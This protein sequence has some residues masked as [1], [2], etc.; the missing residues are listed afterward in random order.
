VRLPPSSLGALDAFAA[1][2]VAEPHVTPDPSL[3]NLIDGGL[4]LKLVT[5]V[6]REFWR[7]QLGDS[8]MTRA[9]V[10]LAEKLGVPAVILPW[11]ALIIAGFDGDEFIERWTEVSAADV[12]LEPYVC[13]L[14][15][16]GGDVIES[17]YRCL[18]EA[19]SKARRAASAEPRPV[20]E[21][22]H[23]RR[24]GWWSR[25]VVNQGGEGWLAMPIDVSPSRCRWRLDGDDPSGLVVDVLNSEEVAEVGE[26]AAVRL[27]GWA[28]RPLRPGSPTGLLATRIADAA[29][30]QGLPFWIPGVDEEALRFVLGLPGTVWV[31]GPAVPR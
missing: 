10:E 26:V 1:A 30:R 27:P 25:D 29:A 11:P 15:T 20:H 21:L 3:L 23:G 14:L 31:D 12:G 6:D 4:P 19:P 28:A 16:D 13:P 5:T 17:A 8:A 2:D 9:L 22:P 18:F 7:V 24:V